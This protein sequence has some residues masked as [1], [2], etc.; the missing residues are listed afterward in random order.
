MN[1]IHGQD[2]HKFPLLKEMS[3]KAWVVRESSNGKTRVGCAVLY[4]PEEIIVEG[5]NIE[6]RFRSH[7][8]HAEVNAISTLVA[9]GYEQFQ[10]ILIVAERQKFTPCGSCM[11]W[12][13]EIGG[14]KAN[15]MFQNMKNGDI[16]VYTVDELMPH[17]PF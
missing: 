3:E 1:T 6:H 4:E 17:Y 11:D 2:I 16:T 14:K 15:V 5:C 9:A 10:S 12:I 7:D 8:I 13:M